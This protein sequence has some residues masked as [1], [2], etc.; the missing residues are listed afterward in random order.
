MCTLLRT[1]VSAT[2]QT[3]LLD[4]CCGTGT[5]GLSLASSVKR[6]VG[7][8]MCA[9][10]VQDARANAARNG[11]KNAE[12]RAAK[13]EVATRSILERLTDEEKRHLV[14]IVDPPRAGLQAEV[15]KALR[16]CTPLTKLI[17]VACHAPSFVN[18]AVLL[19]RPTSTSFPG[20]PFAP[21][22]AYALDLF[23]HTPH[24]ELIVVLERES[25]PT[26][27]VATDAVAAAAGAPTEPVATFT[28]NTL[29]GEP[30]G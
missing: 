10:A 22:K 1:L 16:A 18:N 24:C 7:I 4:V 5:L 14:A 29:L 6:L 27:A 15:L 3:I 30:S 13:A 23:P 9:P 28:C 12:F 26:P 25:S 8:E 2:P 21:T 17:F 20:A 19:C 11:L